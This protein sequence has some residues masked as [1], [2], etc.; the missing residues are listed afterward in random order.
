MHEQ[1]RKYA[2]SYSETDI[3]IIIGD[4]LE[5]TTKVA[6]NIAIYENKVS[7]EDANQKVQHAD[8]LGAVL[9]CALDNGF[10]AE[11]EGNHLVVANANKFEQRF[12]NSYWVAENL[13]NALHKKA[14]KGDIKIERVPSKYAKPA[15]ELGWGTPGYTYCSVWKIPATHTIEIN[16]YVIPAYMVGY[17]QKVMPRSTQWGMDVKASKLES[18]NRIIKAYYTE[19]RLIQKVNPKTGSKEYALVSKDD[20]SKVLQ[21]FGTEKPSDETVQKAEKRVQYF[22]HN[23]ALDNREDIS[24]EV[25]STLDGLDGFEYEISAYVKAKHLEQR[26]TNIDPAVDSVEDIDIS[27]I[28]ISKL[29]EMG[30]KQ[31]ETEIAFED[32]DKYFD[33]KEIDLFV[34]RCKTAIDNAITDDM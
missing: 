1:L 25:V 14:A 16:G 15:E 32:M 24:T 27:H 19:A 26:E 12:A 4:A 21:Y 10:I 3:E 30:G 13:G 31:E 33:K 11:I 17:T 5:M 29:N 2:K 18:V 34:D 8:F 22:K 7:A 9:A 28:T 20:N 6:S 23:A